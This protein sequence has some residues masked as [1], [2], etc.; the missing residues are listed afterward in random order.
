MITLLLISIVIIIFGILLGNII[1]YG[2]VLGIGAIVSSHK[3]KILQENFQKL[4]NLQGLTDQ[5]IIQQVGKPTRI[6]YCYLNGKK[7]NQG[8]L[9]MWE[10]KKYGI[11]LLFD[12]NKKCLGINNEVIR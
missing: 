2:G 12:G 7:Q 4:G 9:Y 5:E 10:S 1:G 8:F 6:E 3:S 11:V